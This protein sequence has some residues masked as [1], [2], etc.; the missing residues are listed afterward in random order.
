MK[1]IVRTTV[2]SVIILALAL[3]SMGTNAWA[4]P[5][6]QGTVPPAPPPVTTV[7]APAGGLTSSV[8]VSPSPD[9]TI[10]FSSKSIP[11]SG[12]GMS[13]IVA[14]ANDKCATQLGKAALGTNFAGDCMDFD[15]QDAKGK[16]VSFLSGSVTLCF[17]PDAGGKGIIRRWYTAAELQALGRVTSAGA[18]VA[19]PTFTNSSGD[20]CTRTRLPGTYGIFTRS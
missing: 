3:M 9:W 7:Q 1:K 15:V 11:A 10:T 16:D 17:L 5:A 6:Q 19:F 20:R 12:V 4:S 14:I 2:M 18:W 13:S 8:T